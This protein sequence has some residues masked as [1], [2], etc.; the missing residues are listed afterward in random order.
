VIHSPNDLRIDVVDLLAPTVLSTGK[1]A[2]WEGSLTRRKC[3]ATP[4][5]FMPSPKR[6]TISLLT[7]N[8]TD[9]HIVHVL[10]I[11]VL[12]IFLKLA[13]ANEKILENQIRNQLKNPM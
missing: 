2:P 6:E 11:I 10:F 4:G 5:S 3:A 12:H 9:R 7:G 13:L 1:L 8:S